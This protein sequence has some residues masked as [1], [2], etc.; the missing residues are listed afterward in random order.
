MVT[1]VKAAIVRLMRGRAG[2]WRAGGRAEGSSRGWGE[3]RVWLGRIGAN[4]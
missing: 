3:R 4:V 2:G 1:D